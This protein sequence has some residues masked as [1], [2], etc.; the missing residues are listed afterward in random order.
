MMDSIGALWAEPRDANWG[1]NQV[2]DWHVHFCMI[3]RTCFITGRR[4]WTENC[5]TGTRV[6]TGPGTPI[7]D[8][9]YIDRFEFVIWQL[10]GT[11]GTI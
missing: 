1:L 10:K 2:R 11:H 9:Y 4:L 6:I 7:I 8:T 5:Y 3:P